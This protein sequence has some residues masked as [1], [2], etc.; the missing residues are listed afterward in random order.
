MARKITKCSFGTCSKNNKKQFLYDCES[1]KVARSNV[2]A[3]NLGSPEFYIFSKSFFIRYE[4]ILTP[5]SNTK[6][7]K[8]HFWNK[9]SVPENL[10][11]P[12]ERP[13]CIEPFNQK[14]ESDLFPKLPP[15]K[16]L[17]QNA[18]F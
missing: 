18:P 5:E 17:N 2:G 7:Y 4:F 15:E 1:V 9:T 6:F 14:G 13:G 11:V 16:I 12:T 10:S 8:E 3:P